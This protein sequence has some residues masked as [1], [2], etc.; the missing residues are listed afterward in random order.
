MKSEI[1]AVGT[2]LLLGDVVNTNAAEIAQMLA[3]IGIGVYHQTVV[4][5][6]GERLT[7]AFRTARERVDLVVVCGGLGPTEDD[8]TRETL[9][10]M[11]GLPLEED[12][13]WAHHLRVLFETRYRS[14]GHAFPENN[15]RQA[16]VPRGATLLPNGRGSAPGIYL[17]HHGTVYVLVPGPPGEMRHLM[18][19][20]VLP[21]LIQHVAR[22]GREAVLVSRVLRVAGL[23]ESRVAELLAPILSSQEN[24]TIAPLAL[25]GEVTLRITAHARDRDHAGELIDSVASRIRRIL[26][27]AVYG[28]DGETLESVVVGL[29]KEQGLSLA[30]G[31]SCTGGLIAHRITNIPGS[32]AVFRG[33]IVAY[34][35][36]LKSSLLGV[37]PGVIAR[38]GAVSAATAEAMARGAAAAA[39]SDCALA[40]TGIA[41]PG[42]GTPEKPVGLT[43]IA[44]ARGSAVTSYRNLFNGTREEIKLR[45]A[46]T[47]LDMLR[48]TLLSRETH[49]DDA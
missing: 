27:S 31:E 14:R 19:D 3:E 11:L 2:E 36:D 44:I 48:R 20:Q 13:S 7:A 47:A 42:G 28:E 1:I 8:L 34:S 5:D 17:E 32:S 45:T 23:G 46:Q 10:A 39:G 18:R 43:Y 26:G 21:R 35:N 15:L 12:S 29:L 16:M 49:H 4:G 40:V 24:P 37:D 9:A 22:E 41:G 6:N 33:G 30:L 38:E 25:P